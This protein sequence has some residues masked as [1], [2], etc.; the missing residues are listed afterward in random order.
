MNKKTSQKSP[1]RYMNNKQRQGYTRKTSR[2][3][4]PP[5]NNPPQNPTQNRYDD[6]NIRKL[7][8]TVYDLFNVHYIQYSPSYQEIYKIIEKDPP[9]NIN[10]NTVLR[11]ITTVKRYYEEKMEKQTPKIEP[12]DHFEYE[13]IKPSNDNIIVN[14][15]KL[16]KSD[17]SPSNRYLDNNRNPIALPPPVNGGFQVP[18]KAE[19][20]MDTSTNLWHSYVVIDSKDRDTERFETPNN[21]TIDLSP[22][23]YT[24]GNERKGYI[25]RGFH[26]IVS[27]ELISC[28]FM[29]TSGE[30]D[31]SDATN[32]PAYVILDMPELS[33]SLYGTNDDISTGFDIL[34]TYT[35]QGNY[36][37]FDS[38]VG[39]GLH[40]IVHK[41][42]HRINLN[43]L[44]VKFKLPNGDLYDF[45]AGNNSNTNTVNKII[46]KIT[47]MKH[48][49]STSFLHKENS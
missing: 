36:K 29:D 40:S 35:T 6:N 34:T 21:F 49:I 17:L 38:P 7:T 31:S 14:E 2:F 37:Y 16:E 30:V 13:E 46:L 3:N 26:N 25:K 27:I 9:G 8:E 47:Q 24:S 20:I 32:P 1:M 28:I 43:K 48:Q 4:T 19:E 22:D 23:S 45:G 44:T 5:Q 11:V 10:S 12:V 39:G 15:L 42:D 33:R 18:S 41:Y